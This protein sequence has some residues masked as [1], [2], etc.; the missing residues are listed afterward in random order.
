M[1]QSRPEPLR[2]AVNRAAGAGAAHW[3][4]D[5]AYLGRAAPGESLAWQ[6]G[7][8]GRYLLRVVDEAGRADAREVR[9]EFSD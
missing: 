1:K 3:F 7:R 6:P 2:L 4:A 5:N 9:V 8:S